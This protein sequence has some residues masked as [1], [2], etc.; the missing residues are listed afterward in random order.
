MTAIHRPVAALLWPPR[1]AAIP[2][3]I[4]AVVL[5]VLG[6]V[7]LTLSAKLNV[8]LPLVPMTLQTLVVLVIGAAYGWRLGAAT[9]L[10]YLAAGALGLPVFAGAATGLAA[11]SG[12]T[13][14][15]LF[16]F[17]IAALLAGWLAERGWDRKVA[18]M[19][20]VMALG[21]IVIVAMGFAWL[22]YGRNLG[23]EKAFAVGVGPFLA[24]AAVK[25]LAGALL[26]PALRRL[27]ERRIG[28]S[29]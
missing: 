7:L 27:V 9:M 26:L 24:G 18:P 28:K 17:V 21:H 15:F 5:V 13:A 1:G 16:G 11:L 22:A 6:I 19:L 2:D 29:S 4:R 25:T 20:L 3:A 8:P 14:G 10:A 12:A 23:I